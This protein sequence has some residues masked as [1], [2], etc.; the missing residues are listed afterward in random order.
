MSFWDQ[1]YAEP[2]MAYGDQPNDFLRAVAD[3]IPP[4]PVLCIAEGQG[5]N[6]VWLAQR[7]HAVTA[8]DASPVGMAR[9]QELARARGV[10]LDTVVAD[11]S[12]WEGPVGHWA[13][14][15][16]TSAHLPP[17]VRARVHGLIPAWLRP[18]GVLVL[19][20]Y[21]PDQLRYGTGGPPDVQMLYS[22]DLLRQDFAG[23]EFLHLQE[24]D[25]EVI[26]GRY[27]NGMAAVTQ[28]LARR[29]S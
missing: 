12:T 25:R 28:C 3:R 13:A 29:I 24:V 16:A 19:E 1:R 5:R 8:L 23:M 10:T 21:R 7:G 6:A 4:G 17:T 11:L 22:A 14:V 26:E 20:A 9:A 15:I 2:E 27:H 18:G